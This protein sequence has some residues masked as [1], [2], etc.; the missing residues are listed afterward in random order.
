MGDCAV[1]TLC[2]AGIRI[3]LV[4]KEAE[5]LLEERRQAA[6]AAADAAATARRTEAEAEVKAATAALATPPA[7]STRP[8]Q[9]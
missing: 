7:R 1:L 9:A 6:L 3:I 8:W 2:V 5:A 4:N